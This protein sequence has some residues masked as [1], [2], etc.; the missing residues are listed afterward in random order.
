[1]RG[2]GEYASVRHGRRHRAVASPRGQSALDEPRRHR[3]QINFHRFAYSGY[4]PNVHT[5][6]S[7]RA[8]LRTGPDMPS[9]RSAAIVRSAPTAGDFAEAAAGSESV[10]SPI[11]DPRLRQ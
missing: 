4:E 1:M 10:A 8:L 3:H 11:T 5:L 9:S 2:E 6:A 7:Q